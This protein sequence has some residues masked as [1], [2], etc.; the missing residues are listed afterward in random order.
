MTST[1]T[2]GKRCPTCKGEGWVQTGEGETGVKRCEP[3]GGEGTLPGPAADDDEGPTVV[4]RDLRLVAVPT[5]RLRA[6][7]EEPKP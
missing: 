6:V 5:T 4:R 7:G 1:T 3:C 2:N